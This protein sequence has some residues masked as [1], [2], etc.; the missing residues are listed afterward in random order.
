VKYQVITS[1]N[2]GNAPEIVVATTRRYNGAL[3]E[4]DRYI[5]SAVAINRKHNP[6]ARIVVGPTENA[7]R[8]AVVT[9][10]DTGDIIDFI[11]VRGTTMADKR[12]F[13]CR[14]RNCRLDEKGHARAYDHIENEIGRRAA[15][16]FERKHGEVED[17]D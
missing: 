7:D 5:A 2:I 4:Q 13:K 9:M 8:I 11:E 3:A 15:E 6:D 12:T 1:K 14:V 16:E 10:L 17:D